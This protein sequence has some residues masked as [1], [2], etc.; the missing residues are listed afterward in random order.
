MIQMKLFKVK[1]ICKSYLIEFLETK[2][3][4]GYYFNL[5]AS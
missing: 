1:E 5:I 2:K 4:V 3:D